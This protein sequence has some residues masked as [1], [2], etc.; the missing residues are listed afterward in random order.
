MNNRVIGEQD[1]DRYMENESDYS[2]NDANK[3]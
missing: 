2:T 3:H 1:E